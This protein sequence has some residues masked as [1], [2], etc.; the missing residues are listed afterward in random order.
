MTP[1]GKIF[2]IVWSTSSRTCARAMI[3]KRKHLDELDL[4]VYAWGSVSPDRAG[5]KRH[6]AK[7]SA[8][9]RKAKKAVGE[10]ADALD[11]SARKMSRKGSARR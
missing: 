5:M 8:C 10:L 7:C 6:L 9:T 2:T 3:K 1:I 11:G 4:V